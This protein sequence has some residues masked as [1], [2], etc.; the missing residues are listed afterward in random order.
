M[1]LERLDVATSA[2]ILLKRPDGSLDLVTFGEPASGG[3]GRAIDVIAAPGPVN[4][5]PDETPGFVRAAIR[6]AAARAV[7]GGVAPRVELVTPP[8]YAQ[9]VFSLPLLVDEDGVIDPITRFTRSS[10]RFRQR[11]GCFLRLSDPTGEPVYGLLLVLEGATHREPATLSEVPAAEIAV[12]ARILAK[13]SI[14]PAHPS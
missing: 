4:S 6:Q 1:W 7:R 11:R 8:G 10:G 2:D 14:A 3:A 13:V 12:V 5:A 9:A